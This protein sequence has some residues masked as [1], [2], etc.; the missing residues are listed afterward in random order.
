MPL[1]PKRKALRE[2]SVFKNETTNQWVC[3][4][5]EFD[6]AGKIVT[7]RRSF[8]QSLIK[9]GKE[10]SLPEQR[11]AALTFKKE[12]IQKHEK[13]YNLSR[14]ERQQKI[15]SPKQ[16]EQAK[17]AFGLL[18][19]L[20]KKQ[21]DIIKAVTEYVSACKPI[22][23]SP[24]LEM[25]L[26]IFL[27][28]YDHKD[29]QCTYSVNTINTVH[30]HL[31]PFQKYM[32]AVDQK[33]R[34]GEVT[35]QHIIDFVKSREV[36]GNTRGN[37]LNYVSQFF[38]RFSDPKDK[39]RFLNENP[40]D[41]A[42]HHFIYKEKHVL[43]SSRKG[44]VRLVRILQY[45]EAKDAL[46]LAYQARKHGIL[47]YAVLAM[48]VGMR[49]SEIYDL[50][51]LPDVWESY[52]KLEEGVLNVDGFGK[53]MDQRSV[54][55]QPVAVEWL[56]L[57]HREGWPICY[58]HNPEGRNIRYSNF[59]ALSL[60]PKDEG[61]RY[62]RIRRLVDQQKP[63]S[64]DEEAFLQSRRPLLSGK[65]VDVFR[66]TYGTNLYYH[67]GKKLD[68]VTS[69][70]GNSEAVYYKHYKGKLDHPKDYEKFFQLGPAAIMEQDTG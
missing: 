53:Q 9:D 15:L 27:A 30:R 2:P 40:A 70:M 12:L 35:S 3:E 50:A 29:P 18:E 64:A 58:D 47:G 43:K 36:S 28:N 6:E 16:L 13:E 21:Q 46:K 67:C 31:R 45:P 22:D 60:L 44:K 37:Y 26:Q 24:S 42:K 1:K 34:I 17:T 7:R 10:G 52:I 54:D 19:Q 56:K 66:H 20:P 48:L 59:R 8:R 51:K 5:E 69:Q 49:P 41:A 11:A 38:R 63:I 61:E 14:A 25:C 39:H 68:Y 33:I 23:A 4:F 32:L 65:S 55:L 57:I 62:V